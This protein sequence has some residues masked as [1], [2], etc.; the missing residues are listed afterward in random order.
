MPTLLSITSS[1]GEMGNAY[2]TRLTKRIVRLATS[3]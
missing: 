3:Q 2:F 1:Q